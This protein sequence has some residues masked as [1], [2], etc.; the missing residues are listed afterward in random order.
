MR[1]LLLVL[2]GVFAA[3]A[4]TAGQ[5]SAHAVLESSAPSNGSLV[6]SAP[7][8]VTL[9]FGESVQVEPDG[10]HVIAPDGSS[11][12]NGKADHIDGR[13]N[14]VGVQLTSTAQGTYT[15]SWHVVSADSHPISGAFTFSVGH[16]SAAAPVAAPSAGSLAVSI[17]YWTARGLEYASFALLIGA[18]AFVF[19]CWPQGAVNRGVRRLIGGSWLTLLLATVAGA[20]LQ[21]P[22][23]AGAGLDR[24]FDGDL[25]SSTLDIALG[26]GVIVRIVLLALAAPYIA[27]ILATEEWTPN[28]RAVFG[29]IGVVL[30]NG[31]AWTWSM[32]GHAAAGL[33]ADLALPVDV[34]HLDAMGIWLGGLVVLWRA[35]PPQAAVQRFS[36]VAFACVG[37]LVATGTYQSWRQLGSWA[38]FFD[39]EYGRLLLLKIAGV[40]VVLGA[41]YFSRRWVRSHVG[42]LR[43]PVLVETAGAVIVLGLTAALVNAEPARTAEAATTPVVQAT[44]DGQ[45]LPFDTGGPGGKGNL[46][47]YIT[48]AH[49]GPNLLDVTVEDLSGRAEDVP[50]LTVALT[51]KDRDVGPLKIDVQHVGTGRYRAA[52]AQI[53]LAGA[54]QVA[55]TVRTSDIDETTAVGMWQVS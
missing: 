32:S 49:T 44:P 18:V 35:K 45:T 11:A 7:S 21:G 2:A 12:D 4:V 51:Q 14:T 16:A 9:T 10:V 1:T 29:G 42:K 46:K 52:E 30:L 33:Q 31:L 19:W 25:F 39:T 36:Q 43:R 13:G 22:Y 6:Q 47:I 38:G 17:V 40:L 3:M 20:L 15:V 26:T 54:W 27:E 53:P 41:A 55:V 37:V 28:R 34:L 24:L 50:E 23:G 5:A 8:R 48:P